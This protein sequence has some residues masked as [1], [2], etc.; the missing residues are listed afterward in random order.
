MLDRI[1]KV[2]QKKQE[3]VKKTTKKKTPMEIATEAGEP[4]VNVLSMDVSP[5]DISN[6]SFELEFN[7]IFVARLIKAGYQQQPDDTDNEIV[8]RWFQ[9]IC[10]NVA[11]ETYEQFQADP[12]NRRNL[13][14]GYTEVK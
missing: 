3:P 13:G 14:G 4:Y 7:D 5:E 6:G 1:K 12:D 2:F 11:M 8:D 9:T 10:R